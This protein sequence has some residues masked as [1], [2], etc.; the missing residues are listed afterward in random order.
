MKFKYTEVVGDNYQN[1]ESIKSEERARRGQVQMQD[2][3]N[4]VFQ[5]DLK[6]KTHKL[7]GIIR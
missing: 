4:Q 7:S 3:E 6:S 2:V 5:Y 1:D